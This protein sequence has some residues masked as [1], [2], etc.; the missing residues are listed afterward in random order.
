MRVDT[1][2]V[3]YDYHFGLNRQVWDQSI[4]ALTD[5]DFTKELPYS[6]G[7]IR[8]HCVHV[9]G[10]DERWFTRIY[11]ELG[12]EPRPLPA[13]LNVEDFPTRER[14]RAEW[15]R[16]ERFMHE[17]LGLLTDEL[18]QKTITFDMPHRGGMKTNQLWQIVAHVV[19]HGTD[20][21][22][23]MLAGLHQLNVPTFDQDLMIYLWNKA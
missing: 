23:Q 11:N 15:D 22:A 16:V 21:R 6:L 8:N 7:S 5:D 2:H 20:H 10:V 9:I 18:L 3:L 19:N 13:R 14:V 17:V 4:M 1:V 12:G